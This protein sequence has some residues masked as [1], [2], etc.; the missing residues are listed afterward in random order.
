MCI[1]SVYKSP[2]VSFV[3]NDLQVLLDGC[4]WFIG[5]GDLNAKHPLWKFGIAAV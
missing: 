1:S 3:D 5:A 2:G 4:D